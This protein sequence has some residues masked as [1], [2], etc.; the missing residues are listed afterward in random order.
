MSSAAASG[1]EARPA[2]L[3]SFL[4]LLFCQPAEVPVRKNSIILSLADHD[5]LLSLINSARLDWRVSP[6]HLHSLEGELARARLVDAAKL[7]A[8][9]VA[10]HSTVWFRD[11]DTDEIEEYTLVFPSEADV[12]CNRISVLAPI[13][14][15]LLGFRVGDVVT[16]QVPLGKRRL[17]IIKVEQPREA[18]RNAE[19]AALA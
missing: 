5:R 3:P 15:A 6:Q 19:M 2:R 12:T 14:T 18:G 10:M 16:W 4:Q 17:E 11:L 1:R 8:D 7:P 13:G 9:V